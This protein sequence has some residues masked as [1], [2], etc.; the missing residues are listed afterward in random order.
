MSPEART[1]GGC[2]TILL[3]LCIVGNVLSMVML[4]AMPAEMRRFVPL[5]T[6]RWWY[7]AALIQSFCVFIC[8]LALWRWKRWALDGIA[9]CFVAGVLISWRAGFPLKDLLIQLVGMAIFIGAI[10]PKYRHLE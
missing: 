1:R 8:A 4:A 6:P 10:L 7:T 5:S 2:L 3:I 9:L